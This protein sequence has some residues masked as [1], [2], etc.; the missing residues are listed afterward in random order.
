MLIISLIFQAM[1]ISRI[2]NKIK[3]KSQDLIK[4]TAGKLP[5]I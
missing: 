1:P 5:L 3:D 2:I 4:E